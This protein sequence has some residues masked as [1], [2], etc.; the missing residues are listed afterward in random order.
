MTEVSEAMFSCE[1]WARSILKTSAV[2]LDVA[3]PE[4]PARTVQTT[5]E[6]RNLLLFF[7][8][9]RRVEASEF[10]TTQASTAVI[11]WGFPRRP[12]S[13]SFSGHNHKERRRIDLHPLTTRHSPP[14]G[15]LCSS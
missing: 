15:G 3:Q 6:T 2:W 8:S 12:V 10:F 14:T 7:R 4:R 1:P 9:T 13:R 11:R 5:R